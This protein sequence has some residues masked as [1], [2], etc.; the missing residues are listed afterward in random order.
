MYRTIMVPT[1][2]TGFDREA[3]R[4]ALRLATKTDA[5]IHLVRVMKA[6]SVIGV[7]PG[8]DGV[9]VVSDSFSLTRDRE[10]SALYLLAEE[11]RELTTAKIVTA[12]EDGPIPDVLKGYCA[13]VSPD[14]IVIS[15][16]GRHGIARFSLGSVT[17]SLIRDAHVPVLVVKP[18]RSYLNPRA[19][20]RFSQMIIPLDGSTLAEEIL[21]P[22]TRLA[23]LEQAE[24]I[25]LQV[26]TAQDHHIG[27]SRSRAWWEEHLPMSHAYLNRIAAKLR[28]SGLEVL[29]EIVVGTSVADAITTFAKSRR[30]GL[31]AIATHGRSGL[32]RAVRG[33]VADELMRNGAM[34][35]LVMHPE[36]DDTRKLHEKESSELLAAS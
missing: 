27:T 17:D 36:P 6:S 35:L 3:I 24:V 7:V 9:A 5:V 16:H 22:A 2:G 30:A 25:L 21:V 33:S 32:R 19:A 26:L 18:E 20:E 15:S 13:R 23:K 28:L 29:T 4:V 14:L 31:V 12:L 1:E 34:S 8:S 10:L 11:C